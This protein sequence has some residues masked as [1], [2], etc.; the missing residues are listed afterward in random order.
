MEGGK[1]KLSNWNLFVKKVY[2]EGKSKNANYQFKNALSD[3]SKRKSEMG[4]MKHGKKRSASL[5][6]GRRKSRRR[7]SRR[8]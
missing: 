4:S 8:H 3:A 1:R 2:K 5:A 7:K 6:G